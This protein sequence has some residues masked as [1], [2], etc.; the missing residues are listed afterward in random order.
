MFVIKNSTGSG[1]DKLNIRFHIYV[2][3]SEDD[4]SRD[5]DGNILTHLYDDNIYMNYIFNN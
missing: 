4:I 5:E 1:Y 3:T 2:L